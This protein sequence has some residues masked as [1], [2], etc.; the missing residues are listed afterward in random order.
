MMG[1][2]FVIHRLFV[3]VLQFVMCCTFNMCVV[4]GV[5]K[6]LN[7]AAYENGSSSMA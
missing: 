6:Y 1:V 5:I 4:R 7:K 3:I 2:L